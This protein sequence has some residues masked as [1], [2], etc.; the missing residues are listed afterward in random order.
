RSRLVTLTGP[1]GCG[2]TRLAL[3]V[4]GQ[5]VE[6]Y[7]DGVW[8]VE[9]AALA[10]P[11][12]VPWSVAAALGGVEQPGQPL[13]LPLTQ[14][15]HPR[16]LLLVLDNC[17]HLVEACAVLATALLRGCPHL[18]LLATSREGLAVAGERTHLVPSLTTPDPTHLPPLA[19]LAAY[20]AVALFL[21]RAQA[22][23]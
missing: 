16:H 2:K 10:E 9:F 1:G 12:L 14:F 7:P 11:T 6:A 5:L 13:I 18:R 4:A 22:R 20:E 21:E 8:L 19:D 15:L 23:W 3:E 17:E